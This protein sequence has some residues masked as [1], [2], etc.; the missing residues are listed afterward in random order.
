L[1]SSD[2]IA[3]KLA[4]LGFAGNVHVFRMRA[5]VSMTNA[6][7]DLF[8]AI[9]IGVRDDHNGTVRAQCFAQRLPYT[10]CAT[11]DDGYFVGKRFHEWVMVYKA[12]PPKS[13][14]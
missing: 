11:R 12:S 14:E 8:G 6:C 9:G 4:H 7:G 3:D 10:R 13:A 1:V 2:R 5:S